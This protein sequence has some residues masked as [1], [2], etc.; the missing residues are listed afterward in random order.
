MLIYIIGV[1]YLDVMDL[2]MLLENFYHTEGKLIFLSL[3]YTVY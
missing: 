3:N 2:D 1:L